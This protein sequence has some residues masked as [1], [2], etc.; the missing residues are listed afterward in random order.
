MREIGSRQLQDI[1]IGAAILGTGGGGDPYVGM[2]LAQ[3]AIARHGPV[4]VVD[5]D[6]VPAHAL[7]IPSGMMGAPTVSTE[8]VPSGAET[9]Q[10]FAAVARHL[11]GG[12]TFTMP[13]EIGGINSVLPICVAAAA[14]VP[15]VDA[16]LMGRAFPEVQM[17]L[18][19]LLGIG[20]S[21]MAVAD[22]KGNCTVLKA[23]DNGWSERLARSLTITMGC[24]VG[25]ALYPLRGAELARA[26]VRATLSL[27]EELGVLVRQARLAHEDV[28]D[29][30]AD[31][32]GGVE[33]FEGKIV[34]V[35][36]RT[37][38]GFARAV[39]QI[40]G[41]GEYTGTVLTLHSQNE[42]LV[43]QRGEEVVASV[44]DLIVVLDAETGQPITTEELRYGFR[45][46]VLGAPCDPRWRTSAGLEVVGP[47]YF[48]F[49]FDFEPV[50][51]PRVPAV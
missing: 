35:H 49:G 28:V 46:A 1:A 24:S 11:G 32:L 45:V 42:H 22:E 5:V 19:T 18:P 47:R 40:Q 13:L 39:I 16:D 17:C 31:R 29:A 12:A 44:P 14:G 6:E 27:S 41:L 48:G 3:E 4:K 50:G 25:V 34:D 43:A 51:A 21:P 2:L 33:L 10:A 9:G 37:E 30:L 26:T 7:V 23:I 20:A 38:G 15:V 36:R 8:K